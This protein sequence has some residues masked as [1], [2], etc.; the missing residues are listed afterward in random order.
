[1]LDWLVVG[2]GIHG[3]HVSHVL[4]QQLGVPRHRLRV[5][6]PHPSPLYLWLKRTAAVGM[7]FLRSSLVHHL[8][9]HPFSLKHFASS[10]PVAPRARFAYPYKRPALSLSNAHCQRV[11]EAFALGSL[12]MNA[13]V[14]RLRLKADGSYLAETDAGVLA[15]RRVVLAV[16]SGALHVPAWAKP[17]EVTPHV[18]HAFDPS[19]HPEQIALNERVVVVGG[20]I[21][22]AQVAMACSAK[23]ATPVVLIQRHEPRIHQLD[24]D[25]GWMGPRHLRRFH[26]TA[27]YQ[28]RRA[29]ID[30]ARYRGSMPPQVYRALRRTLRS[31]CVEVEQDTITS[32][33]R[34]PNGALLL[35][36][37]SGQT[38]TADRV[39]LATGFSA[40][41]PG[42]SWLT[43]LADDLGLPCAP[44]GFPVVSPDLAWRA[45]LHVT[46]ALAELE[47]G[48]VARNIVGARLAADRLAAA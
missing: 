10:A 44:C 28:K 19:F 27:C 18:T 13:T 48:P 45:G 3:T 9:V 41:A 29:M 6:D 26:Q 7:R 24:S 30:T 23:T 38:R 22:A 1:M 46:G 21:S 31:G 37:A 47:V 15:A 12:R 14:E 4:T 17:S 36:G 11:V 5:V 2:G 20:G 35:L 42:G 25:P 33:R 8:D 16:G 32:A 43:H 39:V 40:G 34:M